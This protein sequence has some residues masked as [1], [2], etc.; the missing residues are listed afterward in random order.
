ME[1]IERYRG[2]LYGLAIGDALGAPLEFQ[3]YG[4]FTPVEDMLGGGVFKLRPGDW[5]DD[6]S[7]ALCLAESLIECRG[8]NPVDQMERYLRWYHQGYLSSQGW[9][10][11]IGTTT[12]RALLAFHETR[13]P[14]SG[15]SQDSA[16][17][18]GSIMRLAPV[19]LA[20]AGQPTHALDFAAESS[21]T[22]HANNRCIEACRYL[23]A[24]IVGA[25][26]ERSKEEILA[27]K[28]SPVKDYWMHRPFK[29]EIEEIAMGSFKSKEPP[30]I[31]GSGYVVRSL[32]AAIWAFYKTDN[33]KDGCLL[34]V[35]LG[36]DADTTG[37]VFGQLAGAFYGEGQ[38][39]DSW[40]SKL[41]LFHSIKR[42]AEQLF[43]LSLTI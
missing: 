31:Q 15:L 43:A 6:T 39:P 25:L 28:F 14:F 20:F 41:A 22:T 34:A 38:L 5:T 17:G 1:Q 19:A 23:A 7:M 10:F 4:S 3:E 21:K 32:E 2:S 12:R 29:T 24:L 33:F 30:E 11:D 16:S 27:P 36:D 9:C 13:Q 35:N 37:A 42:Y 8:F 26:Q 18:N 40:R